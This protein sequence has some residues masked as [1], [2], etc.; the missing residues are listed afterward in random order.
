MHVSEVNGQNLAGERPWLVANDGLSET[1]N[2]LTPS[3]NRPEVKGYTY[4]HTFCRHELKLLIV[5]VY[6]NV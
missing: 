4:C 3:V 5:E 6:T 1:I 2:Q